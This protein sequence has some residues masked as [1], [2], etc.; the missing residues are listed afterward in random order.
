MPPKKRTAGKQGKGKAKQ[1]KKKEQKAVARNITVD[2]DEGF[3]EKSMLKYLPLNVFLAAQA[4]TRQLLEPLKI[5]SQVFP[6]YDCKKSSVFCALLDEIFGSLR[7]GTL[8]CG[9]L[10]TSE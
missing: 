5:S 10:V 9:L 3:T 4:C 7:A 6:P 8:G 1:P 2:V